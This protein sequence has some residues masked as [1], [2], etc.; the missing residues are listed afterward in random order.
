MTGLADYRSWGLP[1]QF[2]PGS[3]GHIGL[4]VALAAVIP[5]RRLVYTVLLNGLRFP[6]DENFRMQCEL[7]SV[8]CEHAPLA[9]AAPPVPTPVLTPA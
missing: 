4:G 2:T 1:E 7:A 8:V 6:K 5:E 9:A 3:Y